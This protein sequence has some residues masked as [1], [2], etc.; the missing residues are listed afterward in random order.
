MAHPGAHPMMIN[1]QYSRP[2]N[3]MYQAPPQMGHPPFVTQTGHISQQYDH[4]HHPNAATA[5][6]AVASHQSS[7]SV[8]INSQNQPQQPVSINNHHPSNMPLN[9]LPPPAMST[10][11]NRPNIPHHAQ[12]HHPINNVPPQAQQQGTVPPNMIDP[13]LSTRLTMHP[14]QAHYMMNPYM[15]ASFNGMGYL[16][17]ITNLNPYPGT[18]Y[19]A[20]PPP[21]SVMMPPPIRVPGDLNIRP[22]QYDP[23][24][25][26]ASSLPTNGPSTMSHAPGVKPL[27]PPHPTIPVATTIAPPSTMVTT[28]TPLPPIK[29]REKRAIPIVD[30][31]TKHVY[32]EAELRGSPSTPAQSQSSKEGSSR[33]SPEESS[34]SNVDPTSNELIA[35]SKTTG[36]TISSDTQIENPSEQTNKNIVSD[37]SSSSQETTPKQSGRITDEDDSIR[38]VVDDGYTKDKNVPELNGGSESAER[39]KADEVDLS[40]G[41][42]SMTISADDKTSNESENNESSPVKKQTKPSLP[43]AEGQYSPFNKT[44]RK[45]YTMEFLLAVAK[46]MNI[47]TNFNLN[48]FDFAPHYVNQ[49]GMNYRDSNPALTRR[50][51]QQILPKPKRIIATQSLQ[52]EIDLKTAEIPW[53]PELESEKNIPEG[54]MDTNRLLKV[55]R[56]HLNKLTPN[57]YDSL[58]GKIALL[59]LSGQERLN[60]VIDL[61]FDK[62]VDE[63]GFCELYAKMCKVI[64]SK[65]NNFCSLLVKKCQDEFE[66]TDLYDGLNVDERNLQIENETDVGK[67]KLMAEELYEEMRIRRKKYLGT[68]KLIGE[69]YKLGLLSPRIIGLCMAHLLDELSNENIECLCSLI[70]TVGLKMSNEKEEVIRQSL[71]NTLNVLVELAHSRRAN[72]AFTLE[73]RVKFKILDTIDLSKKGWRPRMV[74]NNPK[75]IEEIREEA[76]EELLRQQHQNSLS[77]QKSNSKLDDRARRA[78]GGPLYSTFPKSSGQKR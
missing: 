14:Q 39:S 41:I 56:G 64:A 44:G 43:Y 60:S 7:D 55:F 15:Q 12:Q 50:S 9:Q 36:D 78:G 13:Q 23:Q 26:Q 68:I 51:S 48:R 37:Q 42:A 71:K 4:H 76:K 69:M 70:A 22:Q 24:S 5:A 45:K 57:K 25:S 30:P 34:I 72:E 16:Y 18:G 38:V 67:K 32:T 21:N 35:S 66:T 1:S 54:E 65:N 17:P 61:V 27:P 46:E 3:F 11:S 63:P 20:P 62:A 19:M 73:S 75:K 33:I 10:T 59:D 77:Q 8:S 49:S 47:E 58:I 52:Q 53:K 2:P 74:E 6:A 40:S 31:L 28:M 29:P